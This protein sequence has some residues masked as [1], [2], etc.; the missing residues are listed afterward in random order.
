[1]DNPVIRFT[2]KIP[3][4]M[5]APMTHPPRPSDVLLGRVRRRLA[6]RIE[7]MGIPIAKLA[8]RSGVSKPTIHRLIAPDGNVR[9]IYLGTL[10]SIAAVL[11]MDVDELLRA[12]PADPDPEPPGAEPTR[13]DGRGAT[14][15]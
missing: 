12:D 13:S 4:P 15:G 11:L 8:R 2:L 14:S 1:M 9:D 3:P 7:T 6:A 5:F 10:A